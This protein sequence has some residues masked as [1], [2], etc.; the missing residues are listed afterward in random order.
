MF[1][2]MRV[3]NLATVME[4]EKLLDSEVIGLKQK[5]EDRNTEKYES[6]HGFS[7]S[8]LKDQ[9]RLKILKGR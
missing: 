3:V 7:N 4:T 9:I 5:K 1:V 2:Q 6:S 8:S